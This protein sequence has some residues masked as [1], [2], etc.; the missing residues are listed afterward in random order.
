MTAERIPTNRGNVAMRTHWKTT[1][2]ETIRGACAAAGISYAH[3]KHCCGGR[4][5]MS[6]AAAVAFLAYLGLH[7]KRGTL[8]LEQ[9]VNPTIKAAKGSRT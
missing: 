9:I 2:I 6:A 3:F 1:P 8:T 5:R 7:R 4:K